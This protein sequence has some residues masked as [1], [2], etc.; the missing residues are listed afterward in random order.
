MAAVDRSGGRKSPVFDRCTRILR[1]VE[2]EARKRA[3][4]AVAEADEKRKGLEARLKYMR[5]KLAK[6]IDEGKRLSWQT[7]V[8]AAVR[9]LASLDRVLDPQ[10]LVDDITPQALAKVLASC[11]ERAGVFAP[12]GGIF[13]TL[14]GRYSDGQADLDLVLKAWSGE[15]CK[16]DRVGRDSLEL[17]HP[18]LTFALTIQPWVLRELAEKREVIDVGFAGRFLYVL[19]GSDVGKRP[20][21]GEPMRDRGAVEYERKIRSLLDG[22]KPGEATTAISMS[23]AAVDVRDAFHGQVEP[24]LDPT[25]GDMGT[26]GIAEWARKLVGTTVRIAGILHCCEQDHPPAV[27]IAPETMK[28]AIDLANYLIQHA[29]AALAEMGTD[30]QIERARE[31]LEWCR[32]KAV[33]RFT[34]RELFE[35]KRRT[36]ENKV[37]VLRETIKLLE[38]HGYVALEESPQ[39]GPG[40]PS[41]VYVLRPELLELW[42]RQRQ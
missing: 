31:A 22:R 10:L 15:A 40:R 16:V 13:R 1:D 9:E 35:S 23:H 18:L 38:A 36:F 29:R 17:E 39:E 24:R 12:E 42:H 32:R 41:E 5:G 14:C 7:A 6:E 4:P 11:G 21:R 33:D 28:A 20:P 27:A 37:P 19:P 2:R 34:L 26:P 30:P 3:R 8:T 25:T